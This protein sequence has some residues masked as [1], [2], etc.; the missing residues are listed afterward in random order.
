MTDT[1][2][3]EANKAVVRKYLEAA[4][5]HDLAAIGVR[6]SASARLRSQRAAGRS[7]G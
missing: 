3:L 2:T 1:A 6:A 5:V 7:R 4:A